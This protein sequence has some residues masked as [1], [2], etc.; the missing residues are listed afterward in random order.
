M[1]K[2]NR[3]RLI[4][5]ANISVIFI[6]G[7]LLAVVKYGHL[8]RSENAFSDHYYYDQLSGKDQEAYRGIYEGYLLPARKITLSVHDIKTLQKVKLAVLQDH[9]E[10]F[11]VMPAYDYREEDS[12]RISLYPRYSCTKEEIRERQEEIDRVVD[13]FMKKM[14][15]AASDYDKIR[16]VYEYLIDTVKYDDSVPPDRDQNMDSALLGGGTVC[17]GY[18]KA[19][20]YLLDQARIPAIYVSNE[21]HAWNKVVCDHKTYNMDVTWGAVESEETGTINYDHMLYP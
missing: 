10:I 12:G 11:W 13:D 3:G 5:A 19:A 1:T 21:E 7:I 18:A 9:P 6:T 14:P 8:Q 17:A 16:Y 15:E 2:K 20:R 4:A